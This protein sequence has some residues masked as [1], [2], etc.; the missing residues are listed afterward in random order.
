[1]PQCLPWIPGPAFL[2]R[3]PFSCVFWEIGGQNIPNDW[4]DLEADSCQGACTLPV[5]LGAERAAV[6][7]VVF[8]FLAV[9]ESVILFRLSPAAFTPGLVLAVV[10]AGTL[11]L[12]LPA[13]ALLRT[14]RCV[15]AMRLF[16]RASYYPAVLLLLV[17]ARLLA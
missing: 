12:L 9:A 10:A 5:R 6:L 1:M 4:S 2:F 16:N 8:L 13:I 17:L 15:G 3:E 14:P 11:L 7:I